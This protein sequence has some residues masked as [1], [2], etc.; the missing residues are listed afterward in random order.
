VGEG[1]KNLN[2][3]FPLTYSLILPLFAHGRIVR[4]GRMLSLDM[5]S[6]RPPPFSSKQRA[7]NMTLKEICLRL[8]DIGE[9]AERLAPDLLKCR[10]RA[11]LHGVGTRLLDMTIGMQHAFRALSPDTIE[12]IKN[13]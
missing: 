12:I 7:K 11:I 6:M 8:V 5:V 9:T 10:D 13:N 1:T 3:H 2:G 4:R